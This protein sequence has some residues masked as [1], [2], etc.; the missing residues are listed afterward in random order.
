MV[1]QVFIMPEGEGGVWKC[2]C[3]QH[4]RI[5][6]LVVINPVIVQTRLPLNSRQGTICLP[7]TESNDMCFY[8]SQRSQLLEERTQAFSKAKVSDFFAFF[9]WKTLKRKHVHP[10]R[11]YS[12]CCNYLLLLCRGK[13]SRLYQV[14]KVVWQQN[15][16]KTRWQVESAWRCNSPPL[17]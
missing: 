7:I 2:M 9:S 13:N 15:Y 16:D 1:S 6:S 8:Q 11:P 10:A 5:S 3:L 14:H 12:P 17:I 4:G